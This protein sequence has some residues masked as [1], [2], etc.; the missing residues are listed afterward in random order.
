M[1]VNFHVQNNIFPYNGHF[2]H[3][4]P[5]TLAALADAREKGASYCHKIWDNFM[6]LNVG[7]A[8]S[9]YLSW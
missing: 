9:F 6:R 3:G 5:P 4:T 8:K 1:S 7:R 2:V